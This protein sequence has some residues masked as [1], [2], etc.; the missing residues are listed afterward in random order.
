[1][2]TTFFATLFPLIQDGL[3]GTP[4]ARI[5]TILI[6][7]L[8]L[9]FPCMSILPIFKKKTGA[10]LFDHV[11]VLLTTIGLFGTFVGIAIGLGSFDVN[12]VD[13][14]LPQLLMGMKLAFWTSILGMA[15]SIVYKIIQA[16]SGFFTSQEKYVGVSSDDIYNIMSEQHKVLTRQ[17]AIL[18][19]IK[20]N[21]ASQKEDKAIYEQINLFRR[22]AKEYFDNGQQTTELYLKE[23]SIKLQDFMQNLTKNS[24]ETLVEALSDV[25][26]DFNTKIN[27]QF[28]E[29]FKELNKAVG[30]LLTWQENYRSHIEQVETLFEIAS[31]KII[32]VSLTMEKISASTSSIPRAMDSLTK[33]LNALEVELEKA[34]ELLEGFA[35]LRN[36][37][38]NVFP[39]IKRGLEDLTVSLSESVLKSAGMTGNAVLKQEEILKEATAQQKVFASHYKTIMEK[40]LEHLN[41][42]LSDSLTCQEKILDSISERYTKLALV[43]ENLIREG[44]ESIEA[45]FS[46][47]FAHIG[48]ELEA[49]FADF[50]EMMEK[51]MSNAIIRLGR[52]MA[53]IAD[54]LVKE[55]SKIVDQYSKLSESFPLL[56][57]EIEFSRKE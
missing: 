46:D 1:M 7:S 36:D 9:F 22:D 6:L 33:L 40:D 43:H 28:G 14:S 13:S 5:F 18:S 41:G 52:Q 30:A 31:E 10:I 45:A 53:S 38:E 49:K 23:I 27:E 17:E 54:K 48:D 44:K 26:R 42:M 29:N 24:T 35:S 2:D 47:V 50:D 20:E 32:T 56:L 15:C 55:N 3:W 16:F 57:K 39:T 4:V 11:P 34:S 51:E 37:A 19:N 12:A 25:I 21:I 8:A